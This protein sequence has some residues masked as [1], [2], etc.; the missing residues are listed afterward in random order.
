[1]AREDSSQFAPSWF[2]AYET[3]NNQGREQRLRAFVRLWVAFMRARVFIAIVLLALQIFLVVTGSGGPD[4][5]LLLAAVQRHHALRLRQE[6]RQRR[7]HLDPLWVLVAVL[8]TAE[9]DHIEQLNKRTETR[10]ERC[11]IQLMS[12]SLEG[13]MVRDGCDFL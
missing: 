3:G 12:Y 4:W 7:W 11:S 1:M 10:D 13:Q 9:E 2:V 6:Q 8:E 5:L